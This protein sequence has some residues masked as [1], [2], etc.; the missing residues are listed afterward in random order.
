MWIVEC[1]L[2][3]SRNLRG[4]QAV[5]GAG[6]FWNSFGL[7]MFIELQLHSMFFGRHLGK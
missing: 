5:E 4:Q 2:P 1:G 6:V 3:T 7:Y